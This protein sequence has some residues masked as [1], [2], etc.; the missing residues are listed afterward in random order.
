MVGW[1]RTD[2]RRIA[3][4]LLVLLTAACWGVVNP[5]PLPTQPSPTSTMSVSTRTSGIR[6]VTVL[7]EHRLIVSVGHVLTVIDPQGHRATVDLGGESEVAGIFVDG[8]RAVI[9]RD[10][11][12]VDLRDRATLSS[13]SQHRRTGLGRPAP[14]QPPAAGRG[15]RGG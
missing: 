11:G 2:T 12:T 15:R 7:D 9:V 1:R 8:Q 10:D 13:I 14:G 5:P 3:V 4:L 6:N